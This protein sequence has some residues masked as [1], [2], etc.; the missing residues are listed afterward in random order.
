MLLS[1]LRLGHAGVVVEGT[2]RRLVVRVEQLEA[3]QPAEESKV[4]EGV[5]GEGG[6]APLR[7]GGCVGGK[8]ALVYVPAC[9]PVVC[10]PVMCMRGVCV[11]QHV[12]C[13]SC[14]CMHA[15]GRVCVLVCMR[16]V[17][18]SCV[19]VSCW[20]LLGPAGCLV[21]WSCVHVCMYT[22]GPWWGLGF[23]VSCAG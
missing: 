4:G 6:R 15:C 14:A 10:M 19:H 2:P 17:L 16:V 1:R 22:A 11:N 20:P 18:W 21:L 5:G 3:R 12:W 13:V 7:R 9:M 23:L 8:G